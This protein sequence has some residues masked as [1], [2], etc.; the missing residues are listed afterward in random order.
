MRF[1]GTDDV[2]SQGIERRGRFEQ[3]PDLREAERELGSRLV[4]ARN[5]IRLRIQRGFT[6]QRLAKELGV[7]Q[8]RIGQIE[9]AQANLQVDT[10]D[11]IAAVFGVE[12]A[13]L[14]QADRAG[15]SP[16]EENPDRQVVSTGG[17]R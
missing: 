13:R 14:L 15:P 3:I 5:V 9:S 16:R 2:R 8:P 7:S 1:R 6:Q 4:I 12:P 11:R 17:T 10:L